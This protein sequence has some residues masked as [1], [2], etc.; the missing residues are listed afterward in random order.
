M[1]SKKSFHLFIFTFICLCASSILFAEASSPVK[2]TYEVRHLFQNID[3][4]DYTENTDLRKTVHAL[5]NTETQAQALSLTGFTAQTIL[6]KTVE[7]DA[8]TVVY[9]CYDRNLYT[10]SYNDGLDDEEIEVPQTVTCRYGS[11]VPVDF[12]FPMVRRGFLFSKW[13]DGKES[14][15]IDGNM[16]LV[17]RDQDVSLKAE[18]VPLYYSVNKSRSVKGSME[19][20]PALAKMGET[21]TVSVSSLPGYEFS[22]LTATD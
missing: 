21:I 7:S 6:Q 8:S 14:Y 17:I 22:Y 2:T 11:I 19:V 3:D 18:W 13:T 9:V 12:F 5:S 15:S 4:D 1:K 20:K 16:L 10:L